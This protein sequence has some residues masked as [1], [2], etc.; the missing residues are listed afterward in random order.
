MERFNSKMV[1]NEK[2]TITIT[3]SSTTYSNIFYVKNSVLIKIEKWLKTQEV[4]LPLEEHEY[5]DIKD[6]LA[7]FRI[8]VYISTGC[9]KI[10]GTT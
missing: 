3:F 2:N 9:P 1:L 5:V 4:Q 8:F 10:H 6:V 7:V